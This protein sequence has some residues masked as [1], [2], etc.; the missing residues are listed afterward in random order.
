MN[1]NLVLI[2][3]MAGVA[4]W[5]FRVLPILLMRGDL[6]PRGLFARFLATTGPAAIATLFVA[7]I[8]PQIL[9]EPREIGPLIVGIIATIVAFAP[10]KSVVFATLAGAV[11]YGAAFAL[12]P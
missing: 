11:A 4:T 2:A 7:S 12:L 1:T 5:G 3:L 9:P 10:Q 8:L 6:K